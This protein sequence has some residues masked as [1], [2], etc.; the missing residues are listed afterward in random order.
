MT[1]GRRKMRTLSSSGSSN[2]AVR[3]ACAATFTL[4]VASLS[5]CV[6]SAAAT[7][8]STVSDADFA[9]LAANQTQDVDEARAQLAAANDE[10]G[11]AKLGV[12]NS[13]HEADFARSDQAAASAEQSRAVTETKVGQDSNEPAQLQ[14][15]REDTRAAQRGKDA[16]DARLA[17]SKKL[18][19]SLTAKVTA[20]ERKVDLMTARVNL[21]KLQALEQ[22]G[23]PAAGKY[24]RDGALKGVTDAQRAHAAAVATAA[25]ATAEASRAAEQ[26][27]LAR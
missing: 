5:S 13:Q 18:T 10:L 17:Y 2:Q 20:A 21:A 8:A 16:A 27:R 7:R 12:V 25:E 15:A 19:I 1:D 26:Q 11:R 3:A 24:D 23:V 22:A 6:T 4:L 14:Q 9:R